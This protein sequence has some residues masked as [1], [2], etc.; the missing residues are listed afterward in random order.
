[1]SSRKMWRQCTWAKT[2][3]SKISKDSSLAHYSLEAGSAWTFQQTN[4]FSPFWHTK[5]ITSE[6]QCLTP[7]S[8]NLKRSL[9][10]PM[11]PFYLPYLTIIVLS[12]RLPL[13][14][15]IEMSRLA[16]LIFLRFS[17][18]FQIAFAI[19]LNWVSKLSIFVNWWT[20]PSNKV[21]SKFSANKLA[22][23]F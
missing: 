13:F 4:R 7:I 14:F 22:L 8:K 1:M 18:L 11:L 3:T 2:S 12:I 15:R 19:C 23:K 20:I 17:E 21:L 10:T 6:K 9:S 16:S 5:S